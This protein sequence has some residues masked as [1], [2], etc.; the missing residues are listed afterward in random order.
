[1]P[2]LKTFA[3]QTAHRLGL[4]SLIRATRRGQ[5]RILMYH[6]FHGDS[7]LLARQ[8]E[9]L[10]EHYRPVT[11]SEIASAV[12]S[13]TALPP[14]GIT[15]TVDDGYA[16]FA[17][18]FPIFKSYGLPVTL[19]VVSGFA[20]KDLWMW[21]SQVEFLFKHSRRRQLT[22]P[23]TTGLPSLS[24]EGPER[25]R[26]L[27]TLFE[28]LIQ[29]PDEQRCAVIQQLP[30]LLDTTLPAQPPREAESLSWDQLRGMAAEGLE[31]GAHTRRHPVLS[32]LADSELDEQI[33]GSKEEIERNLGRP[34]RHFC[35]PNGKLADYSRQ[36]LEAVKASRYESAVVAEFGLVTPGADPFQLPRLGVNPSVPQLYFERLVAGYGQRIPA[37][38]G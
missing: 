10:R 33:R 15:I 21:T 22:V 34:V 3:E 1:M 29:A 11:L 19:Y 16:D 8:C 25:G 18:A 6:R 27:V 4:L 30:L 14:N 35:Y 32:R 2:G 5:C 17:L 31:V 38:I 23:G 37:R 13:G 9:H 12:R 24:L 7:G 20:N 26:S 28:F 36:A